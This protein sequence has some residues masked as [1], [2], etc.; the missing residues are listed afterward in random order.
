M[1][2]G[3]TIGITQGTRTKYHSVRKCNQILILIW[4]DKRSLHCGQQW[5]ESSRSYEYNGKVLE[6]AFS[7]PPATALQHYSTKQ[8]HH[9]CP[10]IYGLGVLQGVPCRPTL[11]LLSQRVCLCF[12]VFRDELN[13]FNK[14]ESP[15]KRT[16]LTV[17][18]GAHVYSLSF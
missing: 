15:T 9:Q 13:H 2:P 12:G 8:L 1:V 5:Y 6:R 17:S 16:L 4:K 14:I 7:R 3:S 18:A 10:R 11:W